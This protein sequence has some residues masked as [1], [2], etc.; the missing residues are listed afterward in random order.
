MQDMNVLALARAL[1]L[2]PELMSFDNE[3][4]SFQHELRLLSY[5]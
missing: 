3:L 4:H 5:L 1:T 2:C